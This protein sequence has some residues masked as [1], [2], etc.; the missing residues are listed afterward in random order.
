MNVKSSELCQDQT[1]IGGGVRDICKIDIGKEGV[2]EQNR[3]A[4]IDEFRA[5]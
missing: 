2:N 5:S 4:W 1:L 3:T